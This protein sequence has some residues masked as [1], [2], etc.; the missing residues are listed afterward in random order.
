MEPLALLSSCMRRLS[1]SKCP[2]N[3]DYCTISKTS[4]VKNMLCS[5]LHCQKT[6]KLIVYS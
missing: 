6:F 1:I 2:G 5:K 4:L 3:E